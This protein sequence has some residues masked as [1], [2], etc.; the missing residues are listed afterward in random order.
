MVS[1]RIA[2]AWLGLLGCLLA[3]ALYARDASA[4]RAAPRVVLQRA[5]ADELRAELLEPK[6]TLRLLHVWASFCGPCRAELP[7]LAREL[8]KTEG[9]PLDIVFLALDAPKTERAALRALR[10]AGKL[11][12][13]ALCASPA[14]AGPTMKELDP[15]WDGTIPSTY[16]LDPQGKIVFAQRG[17][18]K[19][20]ELTSA[21]ERATGAD[22]D[23]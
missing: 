14:D 23:P 11:P 16:L 20:A 2:N 17:V 3:G 12:G 13:R 7:Q 21:I 22:D 18:T 5:S 8:R 4:E 10:S 6:A 9:K 1:T 19:L 15:D